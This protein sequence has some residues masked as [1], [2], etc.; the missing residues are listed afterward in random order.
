VVV[1][2]DSFIHAFYTRQEETFVAQLGARL[3]A[4]L[5]RAVE[6]VNAGVSSYGPDQIS[7]KMEQELPWLRP[8]LV[9]VAIFA[10]NDYGDLLRHKLF[11]LGADGVLV[12][13]HWKLDSRVRMRFE[14]SQRES[15]LIRALR[16]ARAPKFAL[17]DLDF[18]RGEAEREY[19]NF[20]VARDDIVTNINASYYS[21]DVGLTPKSASARYRV[22]LMQ[23]VL[24]RIRDT[25]GRYAVPLVFLFIPHPSDVMNYYDGWRIDRERYP[26]YDSRNQI[27]PLED[28]ARGLGVPFASLYET[29]R[30]NDAKS[31]YLH[32]GDD[33][34]NAAG[35]RLA[36]V[37]MTELLLQHGLP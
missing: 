17:P 9:V 10:G 21:A 27:A 4:R 33:H 12:E 2:G 18:L 23:A 25:A 3:A 30:A 26:D 13:N 15:I 1:Y 20:V 34:W 6:T 7:L 5:G 35:Q 22:I 16:S 37:A 36:A 32:G 31:L 19:Q 14:L 28:I 11:R 24:R 29:F 8:D